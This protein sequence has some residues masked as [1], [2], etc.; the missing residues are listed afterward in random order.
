MIKWILLLVGIS[1]FIAAWFIWTS[2]DVSVTPTG[3]SVHTANGQTAELMPSSSAALIDDTKSAEQPASETLAIF[4]PIK[5]PQASLTMAQA[6][7]RPVGFVYVNP[8]MTEGI[9]PNVF[10]AF[11]WQK[12]PTE[13]RVAI[14]V[15]STKGGTPAQR[16]FSAHWSWQELGQ[17]L[18]F[19]A[20]Q[21]ELEIIPDGE[22]PKEQ[23]V[24]RVRLAN[25]RW[26]V[27][28][29]EI[30]VDPAQ[31]AALL[32]AAR[33]LSVLTHAFSQTGSIER[34]AAVLLAGQPYQMWPSAH[35]PWLAIAPAREPDAD[36]YANDTYPAQPDAWN[37]W[38]FW[39]DNN[40]EWQKVEY[41]TASAGTTDD[42][43]HLVHRVQVQFQLR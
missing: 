16:W 4:V 38:R 29:G 6:S 3:G 30:S 8:F 7:G 20:W 2:R 32:E 1:S 17:S 25:G 15:V 40:K 36:A 39:L 10:P 13:G 33:A 34:G 14:L 35:G 31:Q 18:L 28:P 19:R 9:D 22:V 11:S 26:L 23:P 41:L 5:R 43:G 12:L 37:D 21:G 27:E 42:P 24:L